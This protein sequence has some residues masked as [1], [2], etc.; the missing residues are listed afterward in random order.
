MRVLILHMRYA[1]D[2][3]GTGPLVTQ[4]A[5]DLARAGEE[6]RVI[7]SVPHYGRAQVP[8]GYR[9]GLVF[10]EQRHGVDLWRTPAF[11]WG[12]S[13]AL[14]RGVDYVLFTMLAAIYAVVGARPDAVLC[15][16]PPI[17]VAFS[18]WI[19]NLLRRV[20]MVFNAQDIWPDGLVRMGRL[21]NPTLIW[22]FRAFERWTYRVSDRVSVVSQGMRENL[23]DKGV[24]AAKVEVIPNW[25]D[26]GAIQAL[27][28]DESLREE[29]WLR[30]KFVVLFAGNLG[31]AAG[32][33]YVIEA[34]ARLRER[35]EIEFVLVGEGSAKEAL[36]EQCRRLDLPNVQF[37]PTQPEGRLSRVLA[38][39]D[40]SLVT[41]RAGMGSLSVPSKT[42]AYMASSRP[43]LAAVP[44]NS[45][46]RRMVQ[47]AE[48]GTV[49]APED[50]DALAAEIQRQSKVGEA[51]L[52]RA[53]RRGR[54]YAR[55]HF[56]RAVV[57]ERY[58]ALL[59]EVAGGARAASPP[60]SEAE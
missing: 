28:K 55:A 45:E 53:G 4:L 20:P 44:F 24:P 32:L 5:E 50:P 40:L 13:R 26:L 46:V 37:K 59:Q 52:T 7:A 42:L 31:Y 33:E 19:V 54:E 51:E 9:F 49:I 43:I 16:S 35:N 14:G 58:R 34:A 15:V 60:T 23:V 11:P 22:V 3:T 47:E 36:R 56:G 25:V 39:S 57:V 10:R 12:A 8:H 48:C 27:E 29:W 1:P 30:G 2:A 21:R 17:T 6:V 18:G 41:L 38:T